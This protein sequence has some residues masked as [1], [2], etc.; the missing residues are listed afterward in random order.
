MRKAVN[1]LTAFALLAVLSCSDSVDPKGS[2]KQD[3]V[4][5]CIIKADT[6][7]Q[8][9]Y[10][11][12]SYD[13][14]GLNPELN[15]IDPVLK[16]AVITLKCGPSANNVTYNF[17]DSAVA[18]VDTSRYKGAFNFYFADKINL[19][20]RNFYDLPVP[21]SINVQL[22]DGNV[23]TSQTESIPAGDLYLQMGNIAK[24]TFI[25]VYDPAKLEKACGFRWSFL[26]HFNSSS[27]Y[28]Y[29]PSLEISY[30]KTENG[31][32]VR[33]Y[34]KVP[35]SISSAN[36]EEIPMYPVVTKFNY[37]LFMKEYVDKALRDISAGDPNKS[38][39]T[40]HGLR[41]V[42]NILDKGSAGYYASKTTFS[43]EFSVRLDV[44]EFSN[45]NG[46]L[47]VFGIYFPKVWGIKMEAGYVK[48][49]GY[50]YKS[51]SDI[52]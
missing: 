39:Y 16:N 25:S 49:M 52:E 15:T 44:A 43:D 19:I 37:I 38:S 48:G 35:V 9:A 31:I 28:W 26:N 1:I 11:S 33:R 6:T 8:T 7:F 47:G 27:K 36:G 32:P 13:V 3:Y 14:P 4:F 12:R 10:L 22:P 50:K 30:S 24:E 41:L 40:V 45:V 23:L 42:V 20:S 5:Y 2:P 21:V 29:L 17:K 34:A 51:D 18:R 46:S